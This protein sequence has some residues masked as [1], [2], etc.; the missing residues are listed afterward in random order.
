MT[1]KI[2]RAKV[3]LVGEEGVGK[4]SLIRRCVLNMLDDLCTRTMGTKVSKKT[5][6]LGRP[7][8]GPVRVEMMIWGIMGAHDMRTLLRDEYFRGTNGAVAVA[9]L[10][11]RS[12]FDEFPAWTEGLE[13]AAGDL[14]LVVAVNKS[15]CAGEAD[16]GTEEIVRTA[17]SLGADYLMTS[18]KTGENVEE[19]FRRLGDLVARDR[20]GP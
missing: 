15:G 5:V 14:P 1:L 16:V 20:L 8:A 2:L 10:T 6:A 12:T 13:R 9:D 17:R 3:C 18:A 7:D 19:A 11:R 4:T